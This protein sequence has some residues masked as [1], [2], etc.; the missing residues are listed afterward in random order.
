MGMG[1]SNLDLN[2]PLT[3]NPS[4]DSRLCQI[5]QDTDTNT[6]GGEGGR[7]DGVLVSKPR[8][9]SETYYQNCPMRM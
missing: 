2:N 8:M 4:N 1:Q 5:S 7:E 9:H 3:E 6:R